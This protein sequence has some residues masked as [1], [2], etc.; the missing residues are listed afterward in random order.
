ML[1][2]RES[3]PQNQPKANVAV[4]RL[5]A[6]R[7]SGIVF[8]GADAEKDAS[9][10]IAFSPLFDEFKGLSVRLD[11]IKSMTT[12]EITRSRM[13]ARSRVRGDDPSESL[14]PG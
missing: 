6:E 2:N 14:A 12:P 1:P 5:E 9:G 8:D 4:S 11:A 7:V 10:V 3:G 13:V